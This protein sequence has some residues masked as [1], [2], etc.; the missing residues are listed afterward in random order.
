MSLLYTALGAALLFTNALKDRIT[1]HRMLFG[2]LLLGY[3]LVRLFMWW[4]GY[5]AQRG[6]KE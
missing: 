4:R 1:E 6:E 3:G 5:K 2:G